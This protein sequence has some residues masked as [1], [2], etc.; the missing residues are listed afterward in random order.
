MA[1]AGADQ[2]KAELRPVSFKN[3]LRWWYRAGRGHIDREEEARLFGDTRQASPFRLHL[4]PLNEHA[5]K[6]TPYDVFLKTNKF[7]VSI[8]GKLSGLG[9]L[10]YSLNPFGE[11]REP[12]S[13]IEPGARFELKLT[14]PAWFS[15]TEKQALWASLWLLVWFGGLGT[16]SRRGF[17]GL[18]VIDADSAGKLSLSYLAPAAADLRGFLE[19]NLHTVRTWLDGVTSPSPLPMPDYTAIVPG[20][21]RIFVHDTPRSGWEEALDVTGKDMR[22]FRERKPPED[23]EEIRDFLLS[24]VEPET[25]KRAAFGLPLTFFY[26]SVEKR[27]L[28][29]LLIDE[30]NRRSRP[31]AHQHAQHIANL[32]RKQDRVDAMLQLGFRAGDAKDLLTRARKRA[33]AQIKPQHHDRRAS[34]LLVRICRIE[35][36][37][38]ARLYVLLKSRLLQQDEQLLISCEGR[39]GAA[40]ITPPDFDRIDFFFDEQPYNAQFLEVTL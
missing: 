25:V 29:E 12:R 3:V 10:G 8:W 15:E 39:S 24:G 37:Q 5:K 27:K 30:L 19:E 21:T 11:G 33:T 2:Q 14:F 36:G 1:L 6:S 35:R 34:P 7:D 20:W 40:A 23:Y 9:Y 4:K 13:V 28:A 22:E 16:R 38:Y 31:N 32:N 26:R 18:R 17:G